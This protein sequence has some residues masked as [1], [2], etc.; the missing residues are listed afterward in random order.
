MIFLNMLYHYFILKNILLLNCNNINMI[1][2]YLLIYFLSII[3]KIIIIL[4]I[5]LYGYIYKKYLC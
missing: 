1:L 2:N 5:T 4:L 3:N